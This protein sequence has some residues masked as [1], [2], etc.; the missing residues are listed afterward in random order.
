MTAKPMTPEEPAE[1]APARTENEASPLGT[2]AML[3][4]REL[5]EAMRRGE[6]RAFQ[7]FLRRFGPL[8]LEHARRI[9]IAA[10][11]Q[12]GY[13]VEVLSDAAIGFAAATARPPRSLAAYLVTALRH[14]VLNAERGRAR[15]ERLARS[16]SSVDRDAE[17]V[18]TPTCS[19]HAIRSSRGPDWD[20]PSAPIALERLAAALE[21]QLDES[22][23]LVL[24]W[25][26]HGVPQREIARWLG[27]SYTAAAQRIWRLRERLR[28]AALEH[29]EQVGAEEQRELDQFLRRAGARGPAPLSA[30]A[31]THL[32][33]APG[34]Y[35]PHPH[36]QRSKE[37]EKP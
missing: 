8:L 28:R 1:N 16:A 12:E 13:V 30:R 26:S 25:I 14:R 3:G 2:C 32:P 22:E 34:T 27:I 24:V 19:E 5:V 7:E 10:A 18:V 23:R 4:E 29:A 35:G 9:G 6:S 11:E 36:V 31:A 15:R 37:G 33:G 21:S 17:R 20:S